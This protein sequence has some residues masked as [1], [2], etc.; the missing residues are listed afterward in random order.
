VDE[1]IVNYQAAL[2]GDMPT[3][4]KLDVFTRLIRLVG[5]ERNL[6]E[7]AGALIGQAEETYK[8]AKRDEATQAAYRRAVIAAGDVLLW[9]GKME[10]ARGL[11]AQAET[12]GSFIPEQVR[13]ARVGAYPNSL[14]EHIAA[15][16]YGAALDL[17]NRWEETFPTDKVK[18]QTL[19][20]RGKLLALRGQP[21]DAERYLDRAVR[22][23][24]G[25]AFETEARWLLAETLEKL[26]RKDDARKELAKLV[27]TGLN[28]EFSKRAR[29]KL[30]QK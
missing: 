16:N 8:T 22:L 4:E 11:Y 24:I 7:K 29:D 2:T 14:R 20:W 9:Q 13:A 10:G 28:D 19:Y 27:A 17:V 25:A 12:L 6:P 15:G 18:G 5:I 21:Q 26:G 30:L 1:A 23:T 3:A